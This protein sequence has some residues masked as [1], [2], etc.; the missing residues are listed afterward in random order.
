MGSKIMTIAMVFVFLGLSPVQKDVKQKMKDEPD[1]M[2]G[3]ISRTVT[4]DITLHPE[5]L[6]FSTGRSGWKLK[7]PGNRPLATVAYEDG[8][9]FV[10]GG[11]GSYEFYAIDAKTGKVA[12]MFK[13]GD[14]GPTAAVVKNSY[15]VFN[16]ESCIIYVLD[17]KTG[18]KVWEKWMGDPLMSQP[19]LDE[20]YV[21]MAYPGGDGSHHLACLKLKNGDTVW[22][23]KI[24]GDAI[25]APILD[26]GSVYITCFDGT[27]YRFNSKTGK[28]LWSESKMATC[29]PTI[30]KEKIYLSL[31]EEEKL[32]ENRAKQYEGIGTL[33]N[34]DGRLEQKK[35][36]AKR[37]AVYLTHNRSTAKL[38][39][40]R[41]LD[42]SVGFGTAPGAAK[43]EQAKENVGQSSVVGSW[44]YQGSRPVVNHGRLYNAMGDEI[45][46]LNTRSGKKVWS[47]KYQTK[48]EGLGGRFLS[49]P[50]YANGKLFLG[51]GKGELL[52]IKAENGKVL[53]KEKVDGSV[54]FQPA[55]A[56]GMVFVS[57]DNGLLYG[58]PSQDPKDDGWY[59]WGGNSEHNK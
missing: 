36:W 16:T 21:Y 27:V 22:D 40:Q 47:Q 37:E 56:K 12:W 9:I 52:C 57:C 23:V 18:K 30:H 49:P 43:L 3:K 20:Q 6:K 7:I 13:T 54:S 59:M 33:K 50:S 29:A 42:A 35:L 25:S 10:G 19:A 46:C 39:A 24:E 28:L 14:D 26:N 32:S 2:Q 31:R 15:V 58:I 11:F 55:V 5:K 17:A 44:A 41:S 53:W 4:E 45:Q 34:A 38:K 8:K 51:S 1:V 48:E